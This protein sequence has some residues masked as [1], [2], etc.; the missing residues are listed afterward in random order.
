M[1][2]AVASSSC[3]FWICFFVRWCPGQSLTA[4]IE[5]VNCRHTYYSAHPGGITDR[6]LCAGVAASRRKDFY[7]VR[8]F[9]FCH[10]LETLLREEEITIKGRDNQSF[11]I[12]RWRPGGLQEKS[13][14]LPWTVWKA[15]RADASVSTGAMRRE[16]VAGSLTRPGVWGDTLRDI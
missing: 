13:N 1:S 3:C 16:Q 4:V 11:H 6:M 12:P 2:L 8:E 9:L 10:Q 5:R 14:S 7:Q 15:D